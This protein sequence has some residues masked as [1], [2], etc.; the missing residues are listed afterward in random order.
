MVKGYAFKAASDS[1]IN[2]RNGDSAS[3]DPQIPVLLGTDQS[4]RDYFEEGVPFKDGL[5]I[6]VSG[7][8]EGS[9]WVA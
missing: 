9:V 1:E 3:A 6:E 5:Y 8:V 2:F 7:D 4:V